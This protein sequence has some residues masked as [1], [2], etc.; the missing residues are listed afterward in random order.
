MYPEN[1]T[2]LSPLSVSV[3]PESGTPLAEF[4]ET[5]NLITV[6]AKEKVE[7]TSL[8]KQLPFFGDGNYEKVLNFV[9][10]IRQHF[11]DI[12]ATCK[13]KGHEAKCQCYLYSLDY[14]NSFTLLERNSAI[15]TKGDWKALLEKICDK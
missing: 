10:P 1:G 6:I 11:D 7:D 5:N 15:V 14:L 12:S 2:C 3:R 8:L 4:L 13:E 9:R